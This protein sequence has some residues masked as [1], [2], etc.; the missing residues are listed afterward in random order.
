MKRF[1]VDLRRHYGEMNAFSAWVLCLTVALAL[2]LMAF[3]V[4]LPHT[5]LPQTNPILA[6]DL[7]DQCPESGLAVL[8]VGILLSCLADVIVKYDHIPL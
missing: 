8:A 7:M 2:V 4:V 6:A 1:F 5:A 3:C